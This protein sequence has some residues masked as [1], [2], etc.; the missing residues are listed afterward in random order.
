[1]TEPYA[2]GFRVHMPDGETFNGARFPSGRCITEDDLG[3]AVVTVTLDALLEHYPDA[4][5]EW[6][7]N[8]S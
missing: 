1:M 7:P 8:A 4:R 2:E 6:A 3:F 5:V